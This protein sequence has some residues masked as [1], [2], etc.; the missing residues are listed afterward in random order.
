MKLMLFFSLAACILCICIMALRGRAPVEGGIPMTAIIVVTN[1][2][3]EPATGSLVQIYTSSGLI[4]GMVNKDGIAIIKLSECDI[5]SIF[6]NGNLV[7]ESK[8]GCIDGADGLYASYI[9]SAGV[10]KPNP[11]TETDPSRDPVAKKTG[12]FQMKSCANSDSD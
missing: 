5:K 10:G 8:I 12:R 3:G 6:V 1:E 11:G 4:D 7:Y 9:I 2:R